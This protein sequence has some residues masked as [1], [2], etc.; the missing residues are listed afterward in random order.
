M[1]SGGRVRKLA[2]GLVVAAVVF[3]VAAPAYALD[4]EGFDLDDGCFFTITGGDTTD[5]DDGYAV[6]N[7]HSVPM[8]D[9]VRDREAQ[10]IGYPISQRWTEGPFTLQAFQKVILQWDP[11]KQRMNYYNTLDALANRYPSVELPFVPPHQVL[12]EDQGAT[13][14][15]IIRNH[16]A[17]LDENEAIKERFLSEPDWLNLYGLPIRYEE[18]E[19]DGDPAGVQLLRSQRTV[20]VVWNVPAAGITVGRVN[21]QNVPDKLK[22]LS[23]VVIPDTA[24]TLARVPDPSLHPAIRALPWVADGVFPHEQETL[25]LLRK[26]ASS[27]D[28][29][30]S[31]LLVTRQPDWLQ[32]LPGAQGQGALRMISAFAE[33]PW[34]RKHIGPAQPILLSVL[35]NATED[36]WPSSFRKLMHKP[37]IRDGVTWGELRFAEIA[38]RQTLVLAEANNPQ[39]N[40]KLAELD[41]ILSIMLDMPYLDSFEGYETTITENLFFGYTRTNPR[42]GA[43]EWL[44]GPDLVMR[45]LR[46]FAATGGITDR[47][48]LFPRPRDFHGE[49]EEFAA[50]V[51]HRASESSV[52]EKDIFLPLSGRVRIV[53]INRQ[54]IVASP[55]AISHTL[56]TIESVLNELVAFT[57]MPFPGHYVSFS[58][59]IVPGSPSEIREARRQLVRRFIAYHNGYEVPYWATEGIAAVVELG[60]GYRPAH[61]NPG[62]NEFQDP[63]ENVQCPVNT[64]NNQFVLGDA[65]CHEY[66]GVSFFLDLYR[67]LDTASFRNGFARM[68]ANT[69][70]WIPLYSYCWAQDRILDIPCV[71]PERPP[72]E[73]ALTDAFTTGVSPEAAAN[74]RAVIQR[75]YYGR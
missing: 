11:I 39:Y 28:E 60:M 51:S 56:G 8:W 16:L 41:N 9:F 46:G 27:S 57:Q 69:N 26:L 71:Y 45:M 1:W 40:G 38:L 15:T 18:R 61:W 70:G 34:T 58:D 10:A 5:P 31:R 59:Y 14:G 17:L 68:I 3:A 43:S 12:E 52:I 72:F 21:L 75:W 33:I 20:F 25:L 66:L 48:A 62:L 44:H 53:L 55:T 7:A 22:Q 19:V 67:S 4:C 65:S 32:R 73:T 74:A 49:P 50:A 64:V 47:Q 6:T 63:G 29:L 2:V 24:K 42:T 23:N 35:L 54:D 36:Q 30:L 13:F 37:W